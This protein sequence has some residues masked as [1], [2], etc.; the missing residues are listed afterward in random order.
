MCTF[1]NLKWHVLK[2][3]CKAI[4]N[5]LIVLVT[6]FCR[7]KMPNQNQQTLFLLNDT[8]TNS[9]VTFTAASIAKYYPGIVCNL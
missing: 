4:R 5:V 1:S 2:W 7:I 3:H 9:P 6:F 8:L